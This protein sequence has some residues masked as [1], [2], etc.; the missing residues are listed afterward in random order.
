M[1]LFSNFFFQS[2]KIKLEEGKE[3]PIFYVTTSRTSRKILNNELKD[4]V[5][6]APAS[7]PIQDVPVSTAAKKL[8]KE[9]VLDI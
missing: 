3:E 6:I 5:F 1:I 2:G 4:A 7:L 9:K 8:N